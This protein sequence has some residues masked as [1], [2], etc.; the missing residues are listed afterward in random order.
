VIHVALE[1]SLAVQQ[2]YKVNYFHLHVTFDVLVYSRTS[3]LPKPVRIQGCPFPSTW[4]ECDLRGCLI[5]S[6]HLMLS[7][8]MAIYH[9]EK[10][11]G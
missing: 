7:S 9:H 4:T 8:E 6:R 11:Q 2:Q 3:S 5:A 10:R 1:R